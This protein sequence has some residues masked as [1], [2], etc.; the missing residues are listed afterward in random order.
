MISASIRSALRSRVA[1]PQISAVVRKNVGFARIAPQMR[2]YSSHHEESF[3]EFT[4]R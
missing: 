3:E 1:R 2:M 4:A